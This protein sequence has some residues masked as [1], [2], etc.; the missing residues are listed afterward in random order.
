MTLLLCI[1]FMFG[2]AP[3]EA[4]KSTFSPATQVTSISGF[5]FDDRRN[6]IADIQVELL[7]DADSVLQ[8]TKTDGS[9]LYAF[10]RLSAGIFQ[11]RVQP[12]GTAYISQTKR[13]Q[14]ER[15]RV[16]EQ[17]DFVLVNGSA[18]TSTVGGA[19]FVQEVPEQAQKEYDRAT[20]LLQKQERRQEGLDTLKKAIEI[21]PKYYAALELLG[22]EYVKQK[23]YEP[24][25]PLLTQAFEI[26]RRAYPSL[27]MLSVAQYNLKRMPE[28]VESMRRAITLNQ[29]SMNANLWLGMLLRQTGKLDEAETYLKQADQ[30]AASKSSEAHWQLALLYNQLRKYKDAANE[31]E[32]FLKTQPDARDAEQI[33]QMIQKLRS[34]ASGNNE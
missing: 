21:F 20:D 4:T 28:A 11:V 22:T 17:V 5:V 13:V 26:N 10:R 33:K 16:F 1:F 18:A 19:V 8:R 15:T 12:Y 34:K 2:G 27:Y 31:L 32:L 24:A 30:L 14:L 3:A 9:G 25:I 29:K 23:D 6:P 7:N